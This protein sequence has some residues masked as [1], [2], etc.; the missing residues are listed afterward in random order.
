MKK[1]G[2]F[3]KF[4]VFTTAIAILSPYLDIK[5]GLPN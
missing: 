5:N 2:V 1:V 4:Y 3:S